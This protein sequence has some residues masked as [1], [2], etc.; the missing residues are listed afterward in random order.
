ML[1]SEV[2]GSYFRVV[3]S[4]LAEAAEGCLTE[5]RLTQLVQE[6]AFAEST[7]SIPS[8][9]LE[10]RWPLLDQSLC[11]ILQ[12]T[13][14]MPMTQLQKRW[15]K[16]LL[17]DPRIALFA[18]DTS[19]LEDVRP[20]YCPD[21]FVYF[22]QYADGDPYGDENYVQ[23]FQTVLQ[24]IR[25]KRK[26]RVRFRGHT[27]IRHSFICAP[28]RL[29]YSE[30]DDKFRLLAV[31]KRNVHTIN[32]ARIRSCT[33]MEEFDSSEYPTVQEHACELT[34]LLHD[35]RNAL[36]RALLH[37]SHLEKETRR[38]DDT[39]YEIKIRYDREDETELL[40]RVLSFGPV[41][42]VQAPSEFRTLVKNRI[43]KQQSILSGYA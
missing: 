21:T 6:K 29:E 31:G 42:E 17:Q 13:P 10:G 36:E 14:T 40:I 35:E 26:L 30:K 25:Q 3:A 1:F 22:D 32:M 27:G 41:L 16:A 7:L 11:P 43:A 9:L 8:A 4:V 33:L 19:G 5:R 24:A 34:L 15:L 18:P 2:Y 37:F 20:P 23:N 12:H 39:H 28:Y 38:L